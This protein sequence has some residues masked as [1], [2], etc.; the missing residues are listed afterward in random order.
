MHN[1]CKVLLCSKVIPFI[2][3]TAKA[4]DIPSWAARKER[5]AKYVLGFTI[6]EKHNSKIKHLVSFNVHALQGASM[7]G[8]TL[9]MT[10][11]QV[12]AP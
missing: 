11:I 10:K 3:S 5:C 1:T 7:R 6:K 9:G 2:P 12:L 4:R 8:H